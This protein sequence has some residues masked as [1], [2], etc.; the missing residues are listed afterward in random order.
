MFHSLPFYFFFQQTA[1]HLAAAKDASRA[2]VYLL[3][4]GACS[5]ADSSGRTPLELAIFHKHESA[6]LAFVNSV[7]WKSLVSQQSKEYGTIAQGLV[8]QL[9][10]VMKV[11]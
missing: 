2:V 11:Q 1:L 3:S 5:K 8:E 4:V 9:P 10:Q 6:G 7:H